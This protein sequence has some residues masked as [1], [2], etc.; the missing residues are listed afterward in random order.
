MV[1]F[2]FFGFCGGGMG[3]VVKGDGRGDGFGGDGVCVGGYMGEV[4]DV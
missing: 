1:F 3:F 2:L 4:R